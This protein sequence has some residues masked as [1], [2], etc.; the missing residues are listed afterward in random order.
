MGVQVPPPASGLWTTL[1]DG[2]R[3]VGA[4][5]LGPEAGEWFGQATVAIRAGVPLDVLADTIQPFP[6]FS[7]IYVIALKALREAV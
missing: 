5:A 6:T 7:E 2:E 3:L 1:G 4:H